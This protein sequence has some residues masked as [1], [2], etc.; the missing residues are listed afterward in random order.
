[1]R[2]AGAQD[3][4]GVFAGTKPDGLHPHTGLGAAVNCSAISTILHSL[5]YFKV[6]DGRLYDELMPSGNTDP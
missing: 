6:F 2:K 3:R 5:R 1:M 4:A